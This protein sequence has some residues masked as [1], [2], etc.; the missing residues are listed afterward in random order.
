MALIKLTLNLALRVVYKWRVCTCTCVCMYVC[1]REK[2]TKEEM[3]QCSLA[4][5]RMW[6][7]RQLLT[8]VCLDFDNR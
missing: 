4:F 3:S 8:V 2:Y 5:A 6:S 7:A 1:K